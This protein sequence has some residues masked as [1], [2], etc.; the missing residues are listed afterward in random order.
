[1]GEDQEQHCKFFQALDRDGIWEA[2]RR[3]LH[4]ARDNTWLISSLGGDFL[5][6]Y[7]AY[8]DVNALRLILSLISS[9]IY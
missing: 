9:V 8:I 6:G 3:R 4:D 5:G 1:M 7:C 2:S